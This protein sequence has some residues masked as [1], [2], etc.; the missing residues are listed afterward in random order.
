LDLGDFNDVDNFKSAV[1]SMDKTVKV[2]GQNL[3]VIGLND[4][5]TGICYAISFKRFANDFL[6]I[7][8]PIFRNRGSKRFF[9]LKALNLLGEF[10]S[11]P[12][13]ILNALGALVVKRISDLPC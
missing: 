11:I 2:M 4:N 8:I 7:L 10:A 13:S 1:L 5:E 9:Y 6:D 12:D 3:W